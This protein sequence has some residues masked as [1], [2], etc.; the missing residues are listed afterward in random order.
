MA[1]VLIT[2]IVGY[3]RLPMEQQPERL[4]ELQEV[5]V[6]TPTFQEARAGDSLISLPTGDGIALV[7]FRDPESA[8]RCA[9]E[10]SRGLQRHG[11]LRVR[12]GV[13]SGPVYRVSDINANRNV[14]GGGINIAQR[15]MDCGD[16]GH[17]LVSG[18]AAEMLLQLS[19][20]ADKLH[21]LG[22]VSVK[23]GKRVQLFNLCAGGAGNPELPQKVRA[24][25]AK[26][27]EAASPT[28][29]GMPHALLGVIERL[30]GT[31]RVS[32]PQTASGARTFEEFVEP[33]FS[34]LEGIHK[35]YL[36]MFSDIYE[37]LPFEWEASSEEGRAALAGT[38]HLL[39][40]RRLEFQPV[41]E[42][43]RALIERLGTENIDPYNRAFVEA[44]IRYF[45]SGTVVVADGRDGAGRFTTPCTSS[46]ALLAEIYEHLDG[47]FSNQ[48]K[49][50]VART[51][52]YH[53][54]AWRDVCAAFA[55]C[56]VQF[57]GERGHDQGRI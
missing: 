40:R 54:A 34:D 1:H 51:I 17:I 38:A 55:G 33:A 37:S 5:I 46:S 9:M 16:A 3:S 14:A 42:K 27:E 44:V 48:L 20:W 6:G 35:D 31:A 19:Y 56:Q 15:V 29:R 2:D 49:S 32:P 41:R 18:T 23:H 30:L 28:P 36:N 47:H 25:R 57:R 50:L 7:F 10:I 21:D 4:A 13:H 24:S 22:E 12:T 11:G 45:P 52:Q 43:V 8:A 39:R 53:E 26:A